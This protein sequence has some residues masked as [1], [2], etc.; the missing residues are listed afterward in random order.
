MLSARPCLR[1]GRMRL[2]DRLASAVAVKPSAADPAEHGNDF[3]L[4]GDDP[5]EPLP[6]SSPSAPAVADEADEGGE[7]DEDLDGAE[8]EEEEEEED[9]GSSSAVGLCPWPPL[10]VLERADSGDAGHEKNSSEAVV[11]DGGHDA[12][13]VDWWERNCPGLSVSPGSESP[14]VTRN[15]TPDDGSAVRM[16]SESLVRDPGAETVAAVTPPPPP[17]PAGSRPVPS[18]EETLSGSGSTV[19]I[20]RACVS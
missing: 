6:V 4:L 13:G 8:E 20:G 16:P 7:D 5:A 2:G 12:N 18:L 19:M 17:P 15:A 3:L 11:D 9:G 10:G 1:G 14:C